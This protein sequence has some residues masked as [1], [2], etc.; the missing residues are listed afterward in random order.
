MDLP[1]L[2]EIGVVSLGSLDYPLPPESVRVSGHGRI[3]LW[4]PLSVGGP[5]Q[6]Y[7]GHRLVSL[8]L[9]YFLSSHPLGTGPV[10]EPSHD[11]QGYPRLLP[12]K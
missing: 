10:P 6:H 9:F 12:S 5:Y 1:R 3:A 11:G 2:R 4:S 8:R 7:S